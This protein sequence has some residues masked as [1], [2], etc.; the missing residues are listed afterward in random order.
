MKNINT[1][2]GIKKERIFKKRFYYIIL[3]EKQYK[4][5]RDY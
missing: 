5:K 2:C 4:G 3:Y 1:P